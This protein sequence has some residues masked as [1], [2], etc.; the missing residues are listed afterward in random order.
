MGPGARQA[1][2]ALRATQMTNCF[3]FVTCGAVIG[4]ISGSTLE[5]KYDKRRPQQLIP[6][7]GHFTDD[8][9]LTCAVATGMQAALSRMDRSEILISPSAQEEIKGAISESIRKFGLMYPHAGYG[10]SFKQWLFSG[11]PD[12]YGSFGNGAAMRCSYAG[13]AAQTLKEAELLGALSAEVTHN[14]RDAMT[15]A[16]VIAGCIFILRQGG[17]KLELLKYASQYYNFDFSLDALR[18]IHAFNITASGTAPVAIAA[19]LES[20]S[21]ADALELADSMGGDVD[22]L[23]AIAGSIS[24][25][26]YSV[27]AGLLELAINKLDD[28]LKD[29]F[30]QIQQRW[31]GEGNSVLPKPASSAPLRSATCWQKEIK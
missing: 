24:E 13:W 4:D 27:P 17:D 25:A 12:P 11:D 18:P 3:Y 7:R 19:F 15:A 21:F 23:A 14:H 9:V 31:L 2:F 30:Y 5:G 20:D 26:A 10:S 22:T 6:P 1:F 16:A 28:P 29:A 8:T